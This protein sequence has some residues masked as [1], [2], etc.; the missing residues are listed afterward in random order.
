MGTRLIAKDLNWI[1]F[2]RLTDTLNIKAKIRYHHE[3]A[4][5]RVMPF[6]KN[7]VLVNFQNPQSAIS[8]GQSIVFY[9][10]NVVLG[11]GIIERE[12]K[13]ECN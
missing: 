13:S 10:G 1:N 5:A 11:G 3:E 8:P 6:E 12:V 4:L 9:K 7:R 2:D